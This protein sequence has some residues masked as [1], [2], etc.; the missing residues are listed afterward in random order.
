[1]FQ[2]LRTGYQFLQFA[3]SPLNVAKTYTIL[4]GIM[5]LQWTPEVTIP[6]KESA[7]LRFQP[8][9]TG[10][11]VWAELGTHH[12][13][14]CTT[15]NSL[16]YVTE[17][18]QTRRNR[19]STV[20]T[21]HSTGNQ[22]DRCGIYRSTGR[23]SLDGTAGVKARVGSQNQLDQSRNVSSKR[24]KTEKNKSD[25]TT[26]TTQESRGPQRLPSTPRSTTLDVL[27]AVT[28]KKVATCG[29]HPGVL[30]VSEPAE[31]AGQGQGPLAINES[32][33]AGR[34]FLNAEE[35]KYLLGDAA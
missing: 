6:R 15:A 1:M 16:G 27:T 30:S 19:N 14:L 13:H 32:L 25:I 34:R 23:R 7:S 29:S 20:S 10:G 33:Q 3:F 8:S 4:S 21:Q 31:T 24:S 18:E 26:A 22:G 9:L 17:R 2:V 12:H 11:S 28:I 35:V 5:K